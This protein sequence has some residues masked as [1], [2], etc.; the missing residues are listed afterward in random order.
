MA[1]ERSGTNRKQP[2]GMASHALGW[3]ENRPRRHGATKRSSL[4]HARA[5]PAAKCRCFLLLPRSKKRAFLVF[6][7]LLF[8]A[9]Q[10]R[11]SSVSSGGLNQSEDSRPTVHTQL[12][13]ASPVGASASQA[14]SRNIAPVAPMFARIQALG[15]NFGAG[16][17]ATCPQNFGPL[18][19]IDLKIATARS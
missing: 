16:F 5:S 19:G 18:P 17:R 12:D 2:R 15:A 8:S 4:C 7:F 10:K 1:A 9:Y 3:H 11:P 6:V 13:S 14:S